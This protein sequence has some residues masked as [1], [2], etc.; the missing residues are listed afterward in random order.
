MVINNC[1]KKRKKEKK[2][3]RE[4]NRQ[5]WL[6]K[7]YEVGSFITLTKNNLVPCTTSTT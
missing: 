1:L 7:H 6:K 2:T 3:E 5:K 4:R